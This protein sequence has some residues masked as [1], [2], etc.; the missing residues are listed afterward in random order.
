MT[1][2]IDLSGKRGVVFGVANQ[3]SIAYAIAEQLAAAGAD[4]AFTYLN[5]RLKSG[6]EKAVQGLPQSNQL[7]FECDATDDGDVG[8]VYDQV[9]EHWDGQLDFVVHSIAYAERDDLGGDFYHV[10]I[11]CL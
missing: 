9:A 6:V 1:V 2:Q 4:L 5:D 8:A 11:V 10:L 7:L 3:R